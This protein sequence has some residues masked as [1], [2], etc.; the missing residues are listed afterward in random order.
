MWKLIVHMLADMKQ[1]I[2]LK[3]PVSHKMKEDNDGHYLAFTQAG[4]FYPSP[5]SGG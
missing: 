2:M 3:V 4:R 1:V 5:G